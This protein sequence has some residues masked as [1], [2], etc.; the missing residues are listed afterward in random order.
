[1]TAATGES[2]SIIDV[3][4]RIAAGPKALRARH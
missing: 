2:D 1:L 4:E 3:P